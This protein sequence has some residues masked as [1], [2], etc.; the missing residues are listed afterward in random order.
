MGSEAQVPHCPALRGGAGKGGPAEAGTEVGASFEG[1]LETRARAR[2]MIRENL[3]L[4]TDEPVEF[5][6]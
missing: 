1:P 5:E 6:K 4:V 3:Q 2:S